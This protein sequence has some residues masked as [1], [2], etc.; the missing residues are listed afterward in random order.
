MD[1][2]N[3]I[4]MSVDDTGNDSEMAVG[5]ASIDAVVSVVS[6]KRYSP[7]PCAKCRGRRFWENP[8]REI[9]CGTCYPNPRP[10]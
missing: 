4:D 8:A 10:L 3:H 7:D 9:L 6:K 5:Q 2:S 1:D